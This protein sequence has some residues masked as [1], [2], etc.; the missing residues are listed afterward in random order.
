MDALSEVMRSV[1]LTGGVFLDARFTAPWCVTANMDAEDVKPILANPTQLIAYHVVIE[2]ELLAMI[3]GEPSIKVSAGEALLFPGNDGH[4]L[5]SAHGLPL[6]QTATLIQPAA[7]GGLARVDHGGGGEVTKI[8][9]GFLGSEQGY[10]PLIA[11]LPRFLKLDLRQAASREWV[12]ASVRFAA[13]ELAVGKL[14]SS[15]VMSRLSETLLVEAVREYSSTLPENETG[16]LSGLRDPYVGRALAL[17]HGNIGKDWMTEDLA[18]EV[19][20]SR[21]AFVERFTSV[22]GLPPIRYLTVWRL[23]TAKLHLREKR[24]SIAQLAHAVGYQSE[25]A[26][27][28]AFKRE[29]GVSPAHWRDRS[30]EGGGLHR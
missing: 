19:A 1:R 16:W 13:A 10:N 4:N 22:V 2:G 17:I 8:I 28:R 26:F 15:S 18:K 20:L 30:A 7:N 11:A 25:E 9:C 6:V 5:A 29:F 24:A 14:P 21:S 12:E 23:R 3:P 27:S